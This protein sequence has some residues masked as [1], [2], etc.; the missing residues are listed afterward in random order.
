MEIYFCMVLCGFT[1]CVARVLIKHNPRF[2]FFHVLRPIGCFVTTFIKAL[3]QNAN[4]LNQVIIN[5]I[6]F[7]QIPCLT[8]NLMNDEQKCVT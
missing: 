1:I 3:K 4:V 5:C 2:N 8:G 6:F 7:L